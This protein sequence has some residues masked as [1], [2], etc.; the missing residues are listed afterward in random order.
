MCGKFKIYILWKLKGR[1]NMEGFFYEMFV[2][3]LEI[4]IEF[5]FS[6]YIEI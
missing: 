2:Y 3:L 1:D 6:F 4:D 5:V